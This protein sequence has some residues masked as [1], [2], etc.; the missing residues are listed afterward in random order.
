[1]SRAQDA[2]VVI[3]SITTEIVQQCAERGQ[4]VSDAL[5][6]FMVSNSILNKAKV[7]KLLCLDRLMEKYNP[8]LDTIK[9]QV[10]FDLNYA[11]R[12]KS[13]QPHS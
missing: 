4:L 10:Y 5:A 3:K 7:L 1:M 2:G 9:L 11:S 13:D 6:A 12:C 8:S